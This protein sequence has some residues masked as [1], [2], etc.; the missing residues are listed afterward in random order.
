LR[1]AHRLGSA[2]LAIAQARIA[3]N[4]KGGNAR[5]LLDAVPA[6][7]RQDPGYL[8]A[9]AH[10]L[11]HEN[12]IAEAAQVLLSAPC[13]L[14]QVHDGEEWWVERRIM[15]RK[16]LDL[17]DARSA[18]RV[19]AE[20][21]EPTKENSRIERHFMAGWIALRFLDDPAMAATHFKRI[22]DVTRHPT[23]HA[24]SHYW[25]GRVAEALNQPNMRRRRAVRPPITDSSPAPGWGFRR[26][27]LRRRR[28]SRTSKPRLTGSSLFARSRFYTRS[29]NGNW[30]SR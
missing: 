4:R 7:A 12:K 17:G 3:I 26:L 1:A 13:D 30:S 14:A 15:A 19:V 27:R 10:L 6:D 5:K 28:Q 22:Q 24:R 11:R 20:G 2:D 25:L 29:T 8:F 23:S 21:A 18:Y 9:H 16:L